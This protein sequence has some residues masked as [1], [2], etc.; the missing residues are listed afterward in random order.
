VK[1]NQW[2]KVGTSSNCKRLFH[3][4]EINIRHDSLSSGAISS[5]IKYDMFQCEGVPIYKLNLFDP[6]NRGK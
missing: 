4:E 5:A 6:Y 2:P 1:G 3:F